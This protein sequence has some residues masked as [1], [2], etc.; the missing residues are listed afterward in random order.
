MADDGG[1]NLQ[2]LSFD[3][4]NQLKQSLE[5]VSTQRSHPPYIP[6]LRS[7]WRL[8][9]TRL[10]AH[11]ISSSQ[12]MHGLQGAHQQLKVSADKLNISKKALEEVEK[13]PEGGLRRGGSNCCHPPEPPALPLRAAP[14]PGPNN[15]L[16]R[17]PHARADHELPVR[18][19]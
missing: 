8:G 4:L 14:S 3:Q 2:A 12:E 11:I 5:E 7:E 17:D 15:A 6:V 18:A 16:R 9:H 1:I 13:A 19:G 10:S